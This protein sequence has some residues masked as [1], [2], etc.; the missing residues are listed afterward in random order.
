MPLT[1]SEHADDILGMIGLV[2]LYSKSHFC[3]IRQMT[4]T[5]SNV[6]TSL[7]HVICNH[8]KVN[9]IQALWRI[10]VSDRAKLTWH[11]TRV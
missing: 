10:C 7:S 5:N 6:A 3:T 2:V 9:M 4:D 1:A 11:W 8:L